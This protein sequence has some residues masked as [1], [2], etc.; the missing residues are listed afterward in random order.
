MAYLA[1]YL[2]GPLQIASD[3]ENRL[4][5]ER[6]RIETA[7]MVRH[8]LLRPYSHPPAGPPF[9]GASLNDIVI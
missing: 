3:R 2:K 4:A 9:G 5:S 7:G 8:T 1:G 6:R